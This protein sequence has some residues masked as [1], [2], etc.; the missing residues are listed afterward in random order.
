MADIATLFFKYDLLLDGLLSSKDYE[1][2]DS[3]FDFLGVVDE[4][5]V[6]VVPKQ[7]TKLDVNNL[8]L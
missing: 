1:L 7:A 8:L 6:D 5:V 3:A 4:I 2:T